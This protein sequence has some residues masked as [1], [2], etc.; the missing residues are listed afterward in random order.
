MTSLTSLNAVD[1][2]IRKITCLPPL[3]GLVEDLDPALG[4]DLYQPSFAPDLE[5]IRVAQGLWQ[6]RLGMST[7]VYAA[8]GSGDVRWLS[9]TYLSSGKRMRLMARGTGTGAVLYDLEQGVDAGWQAVAGGTGLGGT[10]QPYFQGVPLNDF[11]YFTD[12]LGALRKYSESSG[13]STVVQPTAPAVA[14]RVRSRWYDR[15]EDWSNPA[16]WTASNAGRFSVT[17]TTATNP[18]PGDGHSVNILVNSTSANG[19]TLTM[20]VADQAINSHTIAFY[21]YQRIDAK[22]FT[23]FGF[24][25]TAP[26]QYS[27]SLQTAQKGSWLPVFIPVGDIASISYKRFKV[28]DSS[29]APNGMLTS[30]LYLPGRLE[31]SYRWVY[32]HYDP[33]G[34]RESE[35][36]PISNNSQPSDF[37]TIGVTNNNNTVRAIQ[38]AAV[39][40]FTSDS[41]SDATTTKIRIYRNGGTEALTLDGNGQEVWFQVGE[42]WDQSTTLNGGVSADTTS[43]VVTSA[44][45]LAVGDCLVLDKSV[46]GKQEDVVIT[47]IVGTTLTVKG[48]NSNS[49]LLYAH[50][51]GAAVQLAFMDNVPNEQIDTST[52]I[53]L[54]RDSAPSASRFV[55]LSPDGRLWTFGPDIQVAVSNKSTPLRPTDY[56]VFPAG[57]DPL[58]RRDPIQGWRFE[59]GGDITDEE[60]MWG[61]HFHGRPVTLTKRN[62]YVIY[63]QNQTQWGPD[64]VRK[65]FQVGCLAGDTVQECNGILYWVAPGPVIVRWDG[66]SEPQVVS[67]QRVSARLA[68]AASAGWIEWRGLYHPMRDGNYYR[69]Y[70]RPSGASSDTMRLDFN[71]D[72]QGGVWEPTVYYDSGGTAYGWR[73]AMVLDGGADARELYQIDTLGVTYQAETGLTDAGAPIRIRFSTKKFPL[74]V[75]AMLHTFFLRLSAVTD[76]VTVTVTTGGTEYAQTSHSFTLSLAGSNERQLK[77]RLLRTLLGRWV[78]ISVTGS[79]VN[80]P[81]IRE[82]E[83][84][85]LTHRVGSRTP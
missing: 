42:I 31:G 78:Q 37:S 26:D 70:L 61:G 10:A 72:H 7:A 79:V 32:T 12:R 20:D 39:L 75:I 19:E 28:L 6:T 17:D 43:L 71:L 14:P 16:G 18:P 55:S 5:N 66:Q 34:A 56:E 50:T 63:A 23:Q 62:L 24:G 51:N 77:K 52:R 33:S 38:K 80:R 67:H 9:K 65:E 3:A 47:A 73:H 46:A 4:D 36:S 53:Q 76:S 57:V 21:L 45:N 15:L 85:W 83:V 60:I 64:S 1:E 84:R 54:E 59:I 27:T 25:I 44:T 2:L 8:V 58:T 81:A 69:L 35:P 29:Q 40:D 68:A 49:K 48:Q 74:D 11:V 41:G 82:M 22:P 30:P 13:V